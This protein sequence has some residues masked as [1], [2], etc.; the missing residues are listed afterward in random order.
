[1]GENCVLQTVL[2]GILAV[3]EFCGVHFREGDTPKT[4][5]WSIFFKNIYLCLK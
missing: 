5:S 1:M 3:S 2:Y 4:N